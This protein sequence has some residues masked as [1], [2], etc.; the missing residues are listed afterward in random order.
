MELV[1]REK[2]TELFEKFKG[3]LTQTQRQA[4]QLYLFE[5]LSISEIAKEVAT[6]RQAVHDAIK[7][8]LKRL[9]DISL[10]VD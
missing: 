10:R 8:G 1:E 7:K 3:L 4:L 6:T 9:E 5:D 2:F